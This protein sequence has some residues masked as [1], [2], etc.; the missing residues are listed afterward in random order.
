MAHDA[1]TQN[2][3]NGNNY[4]STIKS[5]SFFSVFICKIINKLYNEGAKTIFYEFISFDAF[6]IPLNIG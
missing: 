6:I 2:K 3:E 4:F 5:S 1:V